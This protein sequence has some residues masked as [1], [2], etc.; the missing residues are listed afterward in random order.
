VS[1]FFWT[2]YALL[3]FTVL[4]A[5]LGLLLLY[6]QFGLVYMDSRRRLEMQGPDVG[7]RAPTVDIVQ[8]PS[9]RGRSVDWIANGSGT[10]GQVALFALPSC[11]VCKS[12]VVAIDELPREWSQL[13]FVW[14][15]GSVTG[16][17]EA[18][19]SA[20]EIP[21]WSVVAGHGM[22]AHRAFDVTAVPFALVIGP[23]GLV[24]SKGL[25]N[26]PDDL[27]RLIKDGRVSRRSSNRILERS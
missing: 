27:T 5:V 13:E 14:V 15:Q 21:S 10:V 19:A 2:T 3:W 12:L 22:D 1:A 26:H 20:P 17:D 11:D 18:I 9:L 4:V 6:R 16:P 8:I 24:R 7:K 25:I 23:D